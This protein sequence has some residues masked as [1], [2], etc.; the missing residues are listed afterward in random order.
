MASTIPLVREYA[1]VVLRL[2]MGMEQNS[3]TTSSIL[4]RYGDTN[5]VFP[6]GRLVDIGETPIAAG[7]RYC[8]YLEKR[9]EERNPLQE[10]MWR[11]SDPQRVYSPI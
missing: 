6:I 3:W 8:R 10:S 7:S 1:Y 2:K 4:C 5:D 11:T 9:K